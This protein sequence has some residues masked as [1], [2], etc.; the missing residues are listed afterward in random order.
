VQ[1]AD[2]ASTGAP[3][4]E[5]TGADVF[6][7]E[8]GRASAASLWPQDVQKLAKSATSLPQ[9]VQTAIPFSPATE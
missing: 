7:A 8:S 5:H 9:D 6:A 3:Q 4:D 1:N 2:E